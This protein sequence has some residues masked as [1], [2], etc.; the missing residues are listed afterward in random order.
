[1][2]TRPLVPRN[3]QYTVKSVPTGLIIPK[4]S[5]PKRPIPLDNPTVK[6]QQKRKDRITLA[7]IKFNR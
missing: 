5:G 4:Y 1:M 2:N 3:Y 7:P 6:T